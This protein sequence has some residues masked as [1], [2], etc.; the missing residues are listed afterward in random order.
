MV[1]IFLIVFYGPSIK[2]K[3][4]ILILNPNF[5]LKNGDFWRKSDLLLQC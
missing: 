2:L 1:S 5:S 3:V 4:A